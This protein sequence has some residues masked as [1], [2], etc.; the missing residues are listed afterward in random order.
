MPDDISF[1]LHGLAVHA[2]ECRGEL[3]EWD[4]GR[5]V[6]RGALTDPDS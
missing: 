2:K 4:E 1:D 3:V 5:G 6:H